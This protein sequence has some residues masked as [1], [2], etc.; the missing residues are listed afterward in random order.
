M[1]DATAAQRYRQAAQAQIEGDLGRAEVLYQQLIADGHA[2]AALFS[3]LAVLY[4]Q[5]ARLEASRTL[6]EQAITQF[7]E[8]PSL[9][10]NYANLLHEL[11][12]Y[13]AVVL[14][15]HQALALGVEGPDPCLTLAQA[16]E[17]L[18]E[19]EEAHAANQQALQRAPGHPTALLNLGALAARQGDYAQAEALTREAIRIAPGLA[20]AQHNL[21]KILFEQGRHHEACA[22]W[23]KALQLDPH[24][25]EPVFDLA[26]ALLE[27][28]QAHRLEPRL[29]Q[30]LEQHQPQPLRARLL[31]TLANVLRDRGC[32]ID[33]VAAAR[34]AVALQSEKPEAWEALGGLLQA[35]GQL[36]EAE[37]SLRQA[38]VLEPGRPLALAQLMA[39]LRGRCEPELADQLLDVDLASLAK[40]RDRIQ[41]WF[42]RSQLLH[43]RKQ[44]VESAEALQ[45]GNSEKRRLFPSDAEQLLARGERLRQAADA[46]QVEVP[47]QAGQ[48][49]IFIVGMPRSGSTLLES[50]LSLNPQVQDLGEVSALTDALQRWEQQG[51][52]LE[53]WYGQTSGVPELKPGHFTTDKMLYNYMLAGQIAQLLPAAR[54]IHCVRHP[55][56][57]LLS[58]QRANFLRGNRYASSVT[59]SAQVLLQQHRLMLHAQNRFPEHIYRLDYDA[60]VIVP[61]RQIRAVIAWLGWEWDSAYLQPETNQRPVATASVVQV[62]APISA[63]SLGGWRRYR[64]LLKAA[65]PIL[66]DPERCWPDLL[67]DH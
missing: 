41:L 25:V 15:E 23:Q 37:R 45:Q 38:L 1:A 61:E 39:Q 48:G 9:R 43:A 63:K 12:D 64:G 40:P 35:N 65:E 8:H 55:Y 16:H 11:G 59:D 53:Q 47:P 50:I 17:C 27:Q 20:K 3:N 54:V 18:G 34:E 19:F 22:A 58:I 30:L 49:R 31:V 46:L 21:G 26:G 33:A 29:R 60:L 32:F 10:H 28:G 42:A 13:A 14:Q 24:N 5:T 57:N 6:L 62:R 4:K 56:D 2:T 44:F 66:G 51:G 36:E 52:D 67:T 7:P